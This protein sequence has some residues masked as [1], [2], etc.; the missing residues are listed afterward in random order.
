MLLPLVCPCLQEN[1][2]RNLLCKEILLF[3]FPK[4]I[5]PKQ[6][7]LKCIFCNN[8]GHAG[9]SRSAFCCV[10]RGASCSRLFNHTLSRVLPCRQTCSKTLLGKRTLFCLRSCRK[11]SG[12]LFGLIFC[13]EVGR[14]LCG[15]F[16]GFFLTRKIKDSKIWGNISEHFL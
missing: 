1:M 4:L 15:N 10:G 3:L 2:R 6:F 16:A 8:F 7:F 11:T 12:E 5:V 14:E 13:S 9:S